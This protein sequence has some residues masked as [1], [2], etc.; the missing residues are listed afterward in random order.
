VKASTAGSPPGPASLAFAPDGN[1]L[2][3]AFGD[4]TA[5]PVSGGQKGDQR[6]ETALLVG[7]S[8][9]VTVWERVPKK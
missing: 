7:K 8:V 3:A 2:L 5:T 4:G 1:T 6:L 9:G